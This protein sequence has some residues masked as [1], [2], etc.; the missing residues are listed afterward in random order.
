MMS[1]LL[2]I[3]YLAFISL[4]LPDSL[5]G[6]GWPVMHTELQVPESYAGYLTMIIAACTIISSLMSD[7]LTSRFGA[8]LVTAISVATTAVALLGFSLSGAFWMLCLWAIPYG[9]GAGAVDAALNN[10]VAVH[11]E[12]RQMNWLHCFWG[13]GAAISPYVMSLSLTNNLGWANGYRVIGLIQVA[14]TIVIFV[15]I[16]LWKRKAAEKTGAQSSELRAGRDVESGKKP[17]PAKRLTLRQVMRLPGITSVLVAFFAYCAL[18]Q[19]AGLWA[20][21]FLV[22]TRE[23]SATTAAQFA[24]L[25]YLGITAGRFLAGVVAGRFDDRTL[26]RIGIVV[27]VVGIIMVALPIPADIIALAGLVVI[28]FGCA[29]IY[30]SLIH[31]TPANFGIEHS[32]AVIGVQMAFAYI[33]IT[34][35]PPLFGAL[36]SLT[37]M[38]LFSYALLAFAIVMLIMSENLNRTVDSQRAKSLVQN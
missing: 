1:L 9:L 18:E 25:F 27:L 19:T 2:P 16:P 14:L 30:P 15:S 12:S 34:F 28:G 17:Q 35:M 6:S 20:A 29:P 22:Q 7:R 37:G 10:F 3:I 32:Q 38:W 33:G 26:V 13:V 36:A 31:A 24:A 8:G 5:V 4:G 11:Y 23:I 21:T